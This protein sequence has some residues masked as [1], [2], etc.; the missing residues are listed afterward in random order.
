MGDCDLFRALYYRLREIV[1]ASDYI[2]VY[3]STV[4]VIDNEKHRTVKAYLW[5][6]RSV[7]RIPEINGQ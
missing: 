2:Q 6:V 5:V 7:M 3:E 4:P 1:L